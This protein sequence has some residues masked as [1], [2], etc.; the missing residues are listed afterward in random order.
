[1]TLPAFSV[2]NDHDTPRAELLRA[3]IEAVGEKDLER[4]AETAL[5]AVAHQFGSRAAANVAMRC[6]LILH[7]TDGQA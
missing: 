1:M 5:L 3:V 6:A 7:P 4:A 2:A